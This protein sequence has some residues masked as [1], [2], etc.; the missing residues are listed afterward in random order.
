MQW[1]LVRL[2]VPV[3][4]NYVYFF[5]ADSNKI[6]ATLTAICLFMFF[7][8]LKIKNSKII[9]TIAASTFGVFLI[10][11]NCDSMRQWLWTDLFNN[12]EMFYSNL[13]YIHE[14]GIPIMVFAACA[15]I[16]YI[17]I[18]TIEKPVLNCTI[19]IVKKLKSK[20]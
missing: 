12:R 17:R 9:N 13:S 10:H 5:V 3:V 19:N 7:N 18:H 20:F 6:L 2:N 4:F 1:H 8:S 16:D 14:I 15:M 11:D